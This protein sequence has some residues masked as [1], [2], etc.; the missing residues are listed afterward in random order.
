MPHD[1]EYGMATLLGGGSGGIH[2]RAGALA[3][4]GVMG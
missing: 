4:R 3:G 2:F 1:K